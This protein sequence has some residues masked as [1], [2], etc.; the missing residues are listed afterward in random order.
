MWLWFTPEDLMH[1][2]LLQSI[3]GFE[4]GAPYWPEAEDVAS[5]ILNSSV[6]DSVYG[7]GGDGV[8]EGNCVADGPFVNLTLVYQLDFSAGEPYCL[9][10]SINTTIFPYAEQANVDECMEKETYEYAWNCWI[11]KPHGAA[12]GGTGGVMGD[13]SL[14]PGDPV[15]FLH[16]SNLDRLWWKWQSPDLPARF[17][18]M[19][20]TNVPTPETLA[21]NGWVAPGPEVTNYNGDYGNTTTLNHTLW[22]MDLL[23]NVTIADVMDIH[24]QTVCA[25]Y[26]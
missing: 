26:V 13:P 3:C 20:G 14:S 22:M 10:R 1:E 18:D 19:P 15:F 11:I 8:G 16:H 24:G 2:R 5:G 4:G 7:I 6:W 25:E 9:N 12:H 21:Q 17:Y 23:P